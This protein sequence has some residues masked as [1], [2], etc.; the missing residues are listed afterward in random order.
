MFD[1]EHFCFIEKINIE[2]NI[3][4]NIFG[5]R[6]IPEISKINGF[7]KI[8]EKKKALF[9]EFFNLELRIV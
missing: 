5:I 1:F 2:Y 3:G 8:F 6:T 9:E 4:K 7:E